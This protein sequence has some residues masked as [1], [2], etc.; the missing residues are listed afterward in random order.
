[1]DRTR[2]RGGPTADVIWL[3]RELGLQDLLAA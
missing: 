2:C 3:R 1:V